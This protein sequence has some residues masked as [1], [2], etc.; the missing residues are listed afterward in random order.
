MLFFIWAVRRKAQKGRMR[1]DSKNKIEE[2]YIQNSFQ[3]A[4]V[5]DI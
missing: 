1:H 4:V 3:F 2:R 5:L